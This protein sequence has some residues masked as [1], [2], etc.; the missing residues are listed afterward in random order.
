MPDRIGRRILRTLRF[1][2]EPGQSPPADPHIVDIA[3]G[4]AIARDVDGAQGVDVDEGRLRSA[5]DDARSGNASAVRVLS[6]LLIEVD[7]SGD[8]SLAGLA[9]VLLRP[10][11]PA[12][13]KNLDVSARRTW[14]GSHGWVAQADDRIG[15]PGASTLALVM[16]SFHPV[17]FVREAAVARLA[18][19]DD[20]IALPVLALRAA[21][22]VPQVRDRARDAIAR[23]VASSVTSMLGVGPVALML[24]DRA[25][26]A[27]LHRRLDQLTTSLDDDELSRLLAAPQRQLRRLGYSVAL[28]DGRLGHRELVDAAM[29]DDDLV[30]RAQC[31]EAAIR[32]A[33]ESGAAE[34]VRPLTSSGTAIVRV[35]AVTALARAGA[36]DVAEAALVDR[37]PSVREAAQA[38]L[39]RAGADPAVRYR[40][41]VRASTT[42]AP[43]AVAGLGETG[44]T[45][46]AQLVVPF[47]ADLRPRGRVEAVR[48]LRRLGSVDVPRLAMMLDDPSAAVTRQVAMTLVPRAVEIAD[49]RLSELLDPPGRPHVRAAAY[50]LLRAQGIWTRVLTDLE[51]YDDG[52][53][54]LR[55]RARSDLSAWLAYEAATTYSMPSGTAAARLDFL[56]R[57]RASSLGPENARLL[58][59]HCGLT[60]PPAQ[61]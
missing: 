23:R 5:V 40:S 13:W 48:A 11:D 7:R 16:A 39:R 46:D 55:S 2:A 37:N 35:M 45:A 31:A 32:A 21:D 57:R 60:G 58:R 51:L 50:R 56:L 54:G 49:Q 8:P 34:D 59:F 47:L 27:W 52:D 9:I 43:A 22:W 15:R 26:G 24:A 44:T 14:W 42:A 4:V 3:Q 6:T 36:A 33:I 18:E 30:I 12:L 53:A 1:V 25:H 38:V 17:G 20:S 29:S 19:I 28:R 10:A 61:R 41:L